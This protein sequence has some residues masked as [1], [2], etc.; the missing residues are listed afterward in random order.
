MSFHEKS[1][2]N[3]HYKRLNKFAGFFFGV[4]LLIKF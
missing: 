1:Q 3:I 4:H 2:Q